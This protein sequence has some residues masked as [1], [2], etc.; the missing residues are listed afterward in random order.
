MN[1]QRTS[2]RTLSAI[3]I[4]MVVAA[5]PAANAQVVAGLSEQDKAVVRVK[6]LEAFKVMGASVKASDL[7]VQQ[8][9]S[10]RDRVTVDSAGCFAIFGRSDL[11]LQMV[12]NLALTKQIARSPKG[13]RT[14]TF[15]DA[16]WGRIAAAFAAQLW[17]G[18]KWS[19][20]SA[21]R[22]KE[23]LVPQIGRKSSSSNTINL[24]L[25]RH[26]G[27][28]KM[29]VNVTYDMVSGL[30]VSARYGPDTRPGRGR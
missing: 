25:V 21:K 12:S 27:G 5:T 7:L 6:A 3:A 1:R 29:A 16:K 23:T 18:A 15:D 2:K 14:L 20:E 4:L 11:G 24:W 8:A 10:Q 28:R 13:A 26:E 22:E 17:Q 9:G 30:P 19:L